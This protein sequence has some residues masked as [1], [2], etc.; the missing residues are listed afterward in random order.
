MRKIKS[1]FD[2][3]EESLDKTP[4]NLLTEYQRILKELHFLK[5]DVKSLR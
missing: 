4:K 2:L 1:S 5:N 3:A